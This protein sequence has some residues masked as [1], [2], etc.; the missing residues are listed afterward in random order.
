[1]PFRPLVLKGYS[2]YLPAESGL[3]P[4]TVEGRLGNTATITSFSY[5]KDISRFYNVNPFQ[6]GTPVRGAWNIQIYES[7]DDGARLLFSQSVDLGATFLAAGDPFFGI[8]GLFFWYWVTDE[9][10]NSSQG[11]FKTRVISGE[12]VPVK[13]E[14]QTPALQDWPAIAAPA[15]ARPDVPRVIGAS[16]TSIDIQIPARASY[17]ARAQSLE[18]W[19]APAGSE[20]DPAAPEERFFQK[21]ATPD[22]GSTISVS[23]DSVGA[24]SVEK[25]WLRLKSVNEAGAS[26]GPAMRDVWAKLADDKKDLARGYEGWRFIDTLSSRAPTPLAEWGTALQEVEAQISAGGGYMTGLWYSRPYKC[27]MPAGA[28]IR[29]RSDAWGTVPAV[30]SNKFT[31]AFSYKTGGTPP[32]ALY[33]PLVHTLWVF[34]YEGN[35]LKVTRQTR[36]N[37]REKARI[38]KEDRASKAYEGPLMAFVPFRYGATLHVILDSGTQIRLLCS[39]DEGHTWEPFEI[40]MTD[41]RLLG[42]TLSPDGT[43]LILLGVA[44]STLISNDPKLSTEEKEVSQG[45]LVRATLKFDGNS[46]KAGP[47]ARVRPRNDQTALPKKENIVSLLRGAGV[48]YVISQ[49]KDAVQVH[50]SEDELVTLIEVLTGDG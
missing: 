12:Y 3:A 33:D 22:P 31:F 35:E 17:P 28:L 1:M 45:D 8:I 44:T 16:R 42:A 18:V 38:Q 27:V 49:D 40:A 5:S 25:V 36:L 21:V 26:F 46:W 19:A 50:L 41:T 48:T 47:R 7:P 13:L 37:T 14:G 10:E 32:Q 15:P 4:N 2:S 29:V 6:I 20:L 24:S 30:V 43:T 39:V 34:S 9:S 23:I 11:K